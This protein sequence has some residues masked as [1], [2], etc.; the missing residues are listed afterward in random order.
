M[1][2]ATDSEEK[3]NKVYKVLKI[4]GSADMFEN[5]Q[6]EGVQELCT[7]RSSRKVASPGL[8]SR[9]IEAKDDGRVR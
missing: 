5:A 7:R 1:P 9:R 2:R 3:I 6:R 8:S 4:T